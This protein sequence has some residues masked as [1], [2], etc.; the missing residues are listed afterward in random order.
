MMK[1]FHHLALTP[2]QT[3]T[4]TM[5]MKK[6]VVLTQKKLPNVLV[7]LLSNI[8]LPTKQLTNMAVQAQKPLLRLKN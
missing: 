4:T 5:K 6:I 8:K 1:L 7:L 2:V 3:M